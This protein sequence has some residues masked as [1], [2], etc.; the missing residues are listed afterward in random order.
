MQLI[1]SRRNI[2]DLKRVKPKGQAS[3]A[4]V[5]KGEAGSYTGIKGVLKES[6]S[7]TAEFAKAVCAA[8]FGQP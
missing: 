4:L 5:H 6:Q 2:I 7:Y 3:A 8:F 1:S